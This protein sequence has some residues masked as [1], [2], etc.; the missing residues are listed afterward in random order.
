M[1]PI[2]LLSNGYKSR[3][4]NVTSQTRINCYIETS[5]DKNAAVAYG[6]PGLSLDNDF[7]SIPIRGIYSVGD[8]YYVV[9]QDKLYRVNNARVNEH[10][11]TLLTTSGYVDIADNG[12][13][14]TIV[15]GTY[16]YTWNYAAETFTKITAAGFPGSSTI[17]FGDSYILADRPGTGQFFRSDS[18][19]AT[20]WDALNYATAETSPD[21]LVRVY[22]DHGLLLLFGTKTM[23]F[24]AVV[25]STGVGY[26]RSGTAAEYGLAAKWSVAK[27]NNTVIWLAQNS[28]GEVQVMQLQG[29][30]PVKVSTYDMDSIF[31]SYTNPGDATAFS[32]MHNGH[33]F[34]QINF[35][36]DNASW[37]YDGEMAVWSQLKHGDNRH[38]SNL[39]AV[40]NGRILTT[41]Y[42]SGLIYY[43]DGDNYTDNGDPIVMEL[44]SKF[45]F[46]NMERLTIDKLRL[47]M[48]TGVGIGET[49]PQI[50]LQ[51]SKDGGHTWGGE[52]WHTIGM[53]G[54]Y[55]TWVAWFRLGQ[56][57]SWAFRF[58]ISDP[59]KRVILGLWANGS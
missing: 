31:N 36:E 53:T 40:Y 48:E 44:T 12:F 20:T 14:L 29:Y 7:G 13:D 17:A 59:V 47:D 8:Y 5:D 27:M 49:E 22:Y 42:D 15:D 24:W 16:G 6:T 28:L 23:E 3:S 46:N 2:P 43:I 51:V 11:G 26:L 10:I 21:N 35:T 25:A 52:R 55:A 37:L 39:S 58:R 50:M 34:Y 1:K 41:A 32:Y 4:S 38:L 30:Q 57:Y 56:A 33:S 45:S 18:Y 19:D 54:V 9:D